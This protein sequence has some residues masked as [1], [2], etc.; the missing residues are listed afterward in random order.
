M[1][2]CSSTGS[3]SSLAWLG[4]SHPVLPCSFDAPDTV[5]LQRKASTTMEQNTVPPPETIVLKRHRV[6]IRD[7][8]DAIHDKHVPVLSWRQRKA[9]G[10]YRYMFVVDGVRWI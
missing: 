8:T 9:Q 7:P 4:T 1:M 3:D 2:A 5:E 10:Q 6:G